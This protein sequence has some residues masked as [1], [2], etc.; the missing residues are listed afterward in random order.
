M[1]PILRLRNGGRTLLWPA[2]LAACS[3]VATL[4]AADAADPS[5]KADPAEPVEAAAEPTDASGDA[6]E[7]TSELTPEQ[8]FEGGANAYSN[9]I[10]FSSGGFFIQGNDA[11]FQQRHGA[12]DGLYGGIEDLHYERE[13]AKETILSLDGRALFDLND[14]RF[15]LGVKREK[16][17]FLRFS[18]NEFPS[19]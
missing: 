12:V 18:F 17:G 10:E 13:V 9:W 11:Q 3:A 16:L 1:K 2:V 15:S 14:Y 5:E 4:S 6:A 19:S 8:M 7:E